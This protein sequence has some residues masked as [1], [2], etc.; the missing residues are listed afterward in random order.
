M[1]SSSPRRRRSSISLATAQDESRRL[2]LLRDQAQ[3]LLPLGLLKRGTYEATELARELMTLSGLDLR[4][5]FARHILLN[6]GGLRVI[7][8]IEE[9]HADYAGGLTQTKVTSD[10]LAQYLTA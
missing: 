2:V 5:A 4:R 3:E 8:A 9:M 7:E 1:A 6:G 10:T